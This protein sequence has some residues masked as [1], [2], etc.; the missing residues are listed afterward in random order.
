MK[1]IITLIITLV[2]FLSGCGSSSRE[3]TNFEKDVFSKLD[4]IKFSLSSG[5]GAW[6]TDLE[7]KSN[8]SF[9]GSYHKSY[10]GN[11]DTDYPNGSKEECY[12]KGKFTMSKKIDEFAYSLKI[13]E[14][15]LEGKIGEEK[16]VD[17]ILFKTVEA[18]GFEDANVADEFLLFLPGKKTSELPENFL[19]W[20]RIA[21]DDPPI[22]EFYGLYNVKGGDGFYSYD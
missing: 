14:F 19:L 17:G 10:P 3:I 7:M 16:I 22:L 20:T 8:G 13:D 6:S 12:F 5:V 9:V 1:R 11:P 2:V 15:I 18:N 4:G 21:V